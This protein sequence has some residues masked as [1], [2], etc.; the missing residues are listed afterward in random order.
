METEDS[1][2][3]ILGMHRSG[4]SMFANA[5]KEYGVSLG[6]ENEFVRIEEA[7][8]PDGFWENH[9]VV[10]INEEILS[11]LGGTYYKLPDF[12]RGW[13]SDPRLDS[14]KEQAREFIALFKGQ[15]LWGWKDPRNILTIEFWRELVPNA[16]FLF[17]WRN[18]VEVALSIG[19]RAGLFPDW[20][21]LSLQRAMSLWEQYNRA[22]LEQLGDS[23]VA[24]TCYARWME[25][26]AKE[27][28]RV[29]EEVGEEVDQEKIKKAVSIVK[30]SAKRRNVSSK[31]LFEPFVEAQTRLTF[32]Q[33]V[34]RT[35]G[36]ISESGELDLL[37]S[38]QKLLSSAM[39]QLARHS[40]LT[41][42][43]W[44]ELQKQ[45]AKVA[46][47]EEQVALLKEI[48]ELSSTLRHEMS[49]LHDQ[50]GYLREENQGLKDQAQGILSSGSFRLGNRI[51]R[52]VGKGRRS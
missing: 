15:S 13:T 28:T 6:P 10:S 4:T 23:R 16:R 11:V 36:S 27:L 9:R 19:S 29:L 40:S 24:F 52:L 47:L 30:P 26:P 49:M 42:G 25:E 18:P 50:I 21:V 32:E 2:L 51:L 38:Y 41:D 20:E 7:D 45:N 12:P 44:S 5:L 39:G 43:Y 33:L 31:M 37:D 35:P 8:N 48:S 14:A 46:P 34:E 17:I 3:I 22:G 1:P